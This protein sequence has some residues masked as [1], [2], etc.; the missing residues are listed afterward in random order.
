MIISGIEVCYKVQRQRILLVVSTR[1]EKV[2]YQM[3]ILIISSITCFVIGTLPNALHRILILRYGVISTTALASSIL[4][5]LLSMN[6]CY[7]LSTLYVY[8]YSREFYFAL[9]H[10]RMNQTCMYHIIIGKSN[11]FDYE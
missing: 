5:N 2:Q 1:S 7:K 6:Y 10:Y 11:V 3:V 8:S 9:Y 4:E